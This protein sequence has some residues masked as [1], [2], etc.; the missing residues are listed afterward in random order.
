YKMGIA[1]A[2]IVSLFAV[3]SYTALSSLGTSN[4]PY[5][6]SPIIIRVETDKPSYVSGEIV[7]IKI[8]LI[9]HKNESVEFPIFAAGFEVFD[10]NGK[11][12]IGIRAN[13]L[14]HPNHPR[15]L[16]PQSE[17]LFD[18]TFEWNQKYPSFQG[19]SYTE[20]KASPGTYTIEAFIC[21]SF[22]WVS[23]KTVIEIRW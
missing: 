17:T 20:T 19:S 21:S 9:N 18:E 22:G 3:I 4:T 6:D 7:K 14:L 10:S 5:Q 23:S 12:L 2:I 15:I 11:S 8:Y 1:F 13:Y 16:P